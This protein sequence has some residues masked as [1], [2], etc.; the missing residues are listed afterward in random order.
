MSSLVLS[1]LD[2][3]NSLFYG[4]SKKILQKLQ[5]VQ[6]T[7]A[8]IVF[9]AKKYDHV[10]PLLKKLHWLPVTSRIEFKIAS[11]CYKFFTDTHFP[12]YLSE[13]LHVYEPKRTLR[14]SNDIRLLLP[15]STRK[16]TFGDRSFSYSAPHI[17]NSLPYSLRHS[18][19]LSQFK[20][21]LKTFFFRKAYLHIQTLYRYIQLDSYK[22]L[23]TKQNLKL[24]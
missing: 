17:W 3:C 8:K 13:L 5:R 4:T 1:K 2:Y 18:K 9:G 7:A 21:N 15:K 14:S 16:K 12:K 20:T 19:S 6:N 11:I 23:S 24:N 22:Y 10:S